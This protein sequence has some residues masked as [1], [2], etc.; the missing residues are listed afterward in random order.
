MI[1]THINPATGS[2][3]AAALAMILA[4]HACA[5]PLDIPEVEPNDSKALATPADRGGPGLK[6]FPVPFDTDTLIGSSTGEAT[7]GSPNSVDY[8]VLK[9]GDEPDNLYCYYLQEAAA[10]EARFSLQGLGQF[11]GDIIPFTDVSVQGPVVTP[12]K[13]IW[14]G[15][16]KQERLYLRVAGRSS[17]TPLYALQYRCEPYTPGLPPPGNPDTWPA[18]SITVRAI[19]PN[20]DLDLWV[21]DENFNAIPGF[22]H[23]EPDATGLTRNFAAG[24]YYVAVTDGNLMNNLPSPPTD[25]NRNKPVLDFPNIVASSSAVSPIENIRLEVS[26]GGVQGFY[27]GNKTHPWQVLFFKMMVADPLVCAP[28]PA[29][30]NNDGGVDGSDVQAFFDSWVESRACAD[31][32]ADGGVD[33]TDVQVFF[34]LWSAG[35]C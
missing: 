27:L 33:G 28:C 35:G 32:N 6:A 26:G 4:S 8:F 31:T 23:D 16:G 19:L 13:T 14:Y 15:V 24:T 18:G 21:Y 20:F 17:G 25:A 30:F 7:D 9:S 29:D 1:T 2:R 22:G 5:Q 10:S 3:A 11:G 12:I 34:D